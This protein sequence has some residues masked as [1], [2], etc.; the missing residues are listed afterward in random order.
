MPMINPYYAKCGQS[1]TMGYMENEGFNLVDV[2]CHVH[3]AEF[4]EDRTEV[5]QAAAEK[6]VC[7]FLTMGERYEDN[8]RVATTVGSNW[9]WFG[10]G[11]GGARQSA[12]DVYVLDE[13]LRLRGELTDL[14]L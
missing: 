13:D 8:L 10:F 4:D 9:W 2:H 5:L 6:G 12:N 11:D 1:D 7:C 14:G 3:S